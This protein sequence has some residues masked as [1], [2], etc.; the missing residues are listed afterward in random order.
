[1]RAWADEA[2]ELRG[3]VTRADVDADVHARALHWLVSKSSQRRITLAAG[4]YMLGDLEDPTH[5]YNPR[6][7]TY[8]EEDDAEFDN[9]INWESEWR[10]GY[11]PLTLSRPLT[12]VGDRDVTLTASVSDSAVEVIG[13]PRSAADGTYPNGVPMIRPSGYTSVAVRLESLNVGSPDGSTAR[14]GLSVGSCACQHAETPTCSCTPHGGPILTAHDCGF[15]GAM[16]FAGRVEVTGDSVMDFSHLNCN[17]RNI[18]TV[19]ASVKCL[20]PTCKGRLHPNPNGP[21]NFSVPPGCDCYYFFDDEGAD[22]SD[23]DYERGGRRAFNAGCRFLFIY[24]G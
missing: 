18:L 11:G 12:L 1:M 16:I 17:K 10:K 19:A 5:V 15:Y 4:T 3:G 22:E 2:I 14:F 20:N 13:E 21:Y 7:P 8:D 23:D 9:W 24:F 6:P